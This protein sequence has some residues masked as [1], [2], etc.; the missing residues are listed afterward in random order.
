[1]TKSFSA[2]VAPTT[3][4]GLTDAAIINGYVNNARDTA[5][6]TLT[7]TADAG[8]TITVYDGATQLGTTTADGGG[9]WSYT[10]GRLL[11]GA[12]SL[13]AVAV[14]AGGN[15][16]AHSNALIFKVDTRPPS[17][18]GGLADASIAHGFVNAAHNTADQTLTGRT[19]AG[20][21]V[22][23]YDGATQIG[24]VTAGSTGTWSY[25]LGQLSEG[26]HALTATASDVAGNTSAASDVMA[27]TVDTAAPGAPS[28]LA[29]TAIVGGYVNAA[30]DLAAQ[31]LTG[32][33]QAYAMV[34]VY[35]GTTKLGAVQANASGDWS[36][37]LG[38]LADGD[39]SLTATATDKAGNTSAASNALAF[40]VDTQAPLASTGHASAAPD[41]GR[42]IL[43]G[44]SEADAV[45]TIS[46]G[47]KNVA[48]A[49]ADASGAWSA[50]AGGHAY[51]PHSF[52]VTATDAAGNKATAISTLYNVAAVQADGPAATLAALA[53]PLDTVV[54][55][56]ATLP[57]G[58]SYDATTHSFT[59]DA[60]AA[61]YD[62]LA[63]GEDTTV[64]VAY[65]V[66]DGTTTTPAEVA[67]T[68]SGLSLLFGDGDTD[69][70]G[71]AT[72]AGQTWTTNQATALVGDVRTLSGQAQGGDD[73]LELRIGNSAMAIGDA[74]AIADHAGGGNDYV[75]AVAIYGAGIATSLGD[76]VTLSGYA[77]GGDDTV[78][79][80][81]PI[82]S[83]AIGDANSLTDHAQGGDDVV[84]PTW[85]NHGGDTLGYGDAQ[86]MS[87]YAVGGDDT[88]NG[89]VAYGDARSMTDYTQGGDDV[90]VGGLDFPNFNFSLAYGDGAILSG[91]ARGGDDTV[92]GRTA[93]GD[94]ASL[95][96]H[97][98][99]GNDLLLGY[100]TV[101]P[102]SGPNLHYGDG[103][104]LLDYAQG[105]DD[106]L[107]G[108]VGADLLWGDAATVAATATRGADL[109]VIHPSGGHD[110]IMD[111]ELGK[112]RIELDGFGFSSFADLSS[113]LQTTANGV[114]ISLGWH[115]DV[116]VRG[117]TVAQLTAGDF[118]FG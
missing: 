17:Q 109:F 90:V 40:T 75:K 104:A 88:V 115:D 39:H 72:A 30:H 32:K 70:G 86:T 79:A 49:H 26:A 73:T 4:A 92:T 21:T 105:G 80:V 13:T 5:S 38:K 33:T 36:Y 31:A 7:G 111:F 83:V 94:A 82:Q 44:V 50:D 87:G 35:D 96:D 84:I 11:D 77:T 108:G 116:L 114:L 60:T 54:N 61:V 118:V 28:G 69:L 55:L 29:D 113:H 65:G 102:P 81:S 58:V 74:L 48:T 93:Y 76:A 6:Q 16:S 25:T 100:D 47:V 14:D 66:F 2:S 27:F 64:R 62:Q 37:T 15:L 89:S 19:D 43:N 68:V 41:S 1:M 46:D 51:T 101:Y 117:V 67:W 8:V 12:H 78:V 112:D 63:P 3:P 18:P 57:D 42:L 24:T 95:T 56:P 71:A 45:I 110:Q 23:I 10:L 9:A 99:G 103:A 91:H 106:T 107:V 20:A 34:A 59:L 53:D 52:T 98:Q 85:L 97:A 22:A